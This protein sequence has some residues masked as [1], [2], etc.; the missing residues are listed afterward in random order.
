MDWFLCGNGLRYER[1]KQYLNDTMHSKSSF[2][3]ALK[4]H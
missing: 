4:V 2:L 1:V 3:F